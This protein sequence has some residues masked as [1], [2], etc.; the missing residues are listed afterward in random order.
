MANDLEERGFAA[1][2]P[3]R[4]AKV[5]SAKNNVIIKESVQIAQ[6]QFDTVR[7]NL[8]FDVQ[9]WPY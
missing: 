9:L 4:I 5:R 2:R 6:P 7:R 3:N 1:D 8:F